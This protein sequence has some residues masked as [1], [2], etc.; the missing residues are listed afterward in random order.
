M[1][2]TGPRRLPRRFITRASRWRLKG[3]GH[4]AIGERRD[5]GARLGEL[6]VA[7]ASST[8]P[9]FAPLHPPANSSAPSALTAKRMSAKLCRCSWPTG[10]IGAGMVGQHVRCVTIPAMCRSAP[11]AAEKLFITPE[12][13]SSKR[14]G[15]PTAGQLVD[16]RHA[17]L[18][19]DEEH[20]QSSD[21]TWISSDFI[22]KRSA[23]RIELVRAPQA[24]RPPGSRSWRAPPRRGL[25]PAESSKSG[26]YGRA[27]WKSGTRRDAERGEDRRDDDRQHDAERVQENLP[28]GRGNR[29]FG[30][31]PPPGAA[32]SAATANKMIS[33]F[34]GNARQSNAVL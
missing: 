29:P 5:R 8:G 1:E 9:A 4:V 12:E 28:L 19:I 26:R 21:T 3:R 14:P 7:C 2:R 25:E 18:G 31:R 24:T 20:F 15:V 17:L 13:V 27:R 33:F 10:G 23:A 34:I 22:R 30:S 32:A 11:V 16:R 6:G